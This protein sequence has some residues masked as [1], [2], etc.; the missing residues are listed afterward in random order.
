MTIR[1]AIAR[2]STALVAALYLIAQALALFSPAS[3]VDAPA[4][5]ATA[6]AAAVE[7]A[8]LVGVEDGQA[9]I[10]LAEDHAPGHSDPAHERGHDDCPLCAA[11]GHAAAQLPVLWTPL[12]Q[13]SATRTAF[14]ARPDPAPRPA[15]NAAARSRAPPQSV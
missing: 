12:P 7:L 15:A 2:R 10:C 3:A 6:Q 9:V 11:L 13:A 4:R 8:R 1:A 5:L 14:V